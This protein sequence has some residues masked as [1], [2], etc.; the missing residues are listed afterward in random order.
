MSALDTYEEPMEFRFAANAKPLRGW[1]AL[2]EPWFIASDVAEALDYRMASDMT[3]RL[4]ED[5]KGT[6]S[7]RTPGGMQ[8]VTIIN[9][10]GLYTA[11]LGS[12]IPGAVAFKRWV[13]REVLPA[14]RR[15][16]SYSTTPALTEDEIVHQALTISVRRV[17]ELTA[18]V[19][20]LTIPASAWTE[21]AESQGDY[22]VS[23]AAKVLSRD[24]NISI[25]RDRLFTFMQGLRWVYRDKGWRA[26]QTQVD[27]GRLVEKVSKPFWHEGRG[28]YM[29]A[30]P[31]VRVTP[32]GLAELHKRL[33]GTGQLALVAAS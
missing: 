16:G 10:S 26:Y 18:K 5:E 11:I 20:E 3:R 17:E 13:T 29:A 12:R 25:G 23:D 14:I 21:L 9:E 32:K 24:P 30:T 22:S 4:D 8:N 6:R 31:T 15:S 1:L 28:E 2:G 33:G 27:N 7:V 19:A